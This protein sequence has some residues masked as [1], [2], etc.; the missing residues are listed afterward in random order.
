MLVSNPKSKQFPLSR[1][2]YLI[3]ASAANQIDLNLK[4]ENHGYTVIPPI[5][6]EQ[7]IMEK[8]NF[9]KQTMQLF[10]NSMHH[11]SGVQTIIKKIL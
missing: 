6:F 8:F 5:C 4:N 10:C 7:S 3:F 9:G 1:N 2:G 11:L